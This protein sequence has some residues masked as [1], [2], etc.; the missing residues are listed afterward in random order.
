MGAPPPRALPEA[1][2]EGEGWGVPEVVLEAVALVEE[3]VG[4]RVGVVE[5]EAPGDRVGVGVWEGVGLALAVGAALALPAPPAD[6]VGGSV[7]RALVLLLEVALAMAVAVA[8]REELALALREAGGLGVTRGEVPRVA[9]SPTRLLA[10]AALNAV[11]LASSCA[12]DAASLAATVA[13]TRAAATS[14]AISAS[15]C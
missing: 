5:G 10:T 8:E 1:G 9:A 6:A 7:P 4:E 2:V 3:G 14:P 15:C 11:R 12:G 13:A